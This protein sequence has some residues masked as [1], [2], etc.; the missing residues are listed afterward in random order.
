MSQELETIR[1][2]LRKLSQENLYFLCKGILGYDRL[3]PSLHK[4]FCQ[5]VTDTSYNRKMLLI[6][7]GNYKTTIITGR[8]IQYLI[9]DCNERVAI[10]CNTVTTASRRLKRIQAHFENNVLLRW[11]FPELIP[12]FKKVVQNPETGDH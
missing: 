4:E 12:D 9:R 5:V 1:Q 6:P 7:R 8:A 10:F 3:L 11:L 2:K